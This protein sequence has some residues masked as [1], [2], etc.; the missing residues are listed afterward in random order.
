MENDA[1]SL[2]HSLIHDV[3]SSDEASD[4]SI[5]L[6][7]TPPPLVKEELPQFKATTAKV[8]SPTAEAPL[9]P[10]AQALA[11]F[12]AA[13]VDSHKPVEKDDFETLELSEESLVLSPAPSALNE[14]SSAPSAAEKSAPL[15]SAEAD[16][17]ALF[18]TGGSTFRF[19]SDYTRR[20][21]RAFTGD[22]NEQVPSQAPR[23]VQNVFPQV[24]SDTPSWV[25]PNVALPEVDES[26]EVSFDPPKAKKTDAKKE[27]PIA[28]PPP[29]EPTPAPQAAPTSGPASLASLS[30]EET[31]KIEQMIREEVHLVCRE[32]VERVAWEVIPELAENL[33][34]K[35]LQKVIE[36]LEQ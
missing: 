21:T 35:E 13:E 25:V 34:K 24:S 20:I 23:A 4:P 14:W 31:A 18:D 12:F 10:N 16:T 8:D 2:L 32:I 28:V 27:A 19:S 17:P 26:L 22:L 30:A 29:S 5:L 1:D 7:E 33:I 9:S 15:A 11:A 36:Q 3:P 6:D